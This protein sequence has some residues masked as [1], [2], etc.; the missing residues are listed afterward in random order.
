M[1]WLDMIWI[2]SFAL[3]LPVVQMGV[4]GGGKQVA[5]VGGGLS[6]LTVAY[7]LQQ[8][9]SG[10][11][12]VTVFEAATARVGGH[13]QQL[14][15]Q[16]QQQPS[17]DRGEELL[18]NIG[19]ATHLGMFAN[20]RCLLRHLDVPEVPVGRGPNYAAPGL[21]RMVSVSTR[22]GGA[23]V[24]PTIDDA[25]DW[26]V[27]WDAF[28]FYYHSYLEPEAALNAL[29]AKHSFGPS[30]LQIL[31]WAMATFEFDKR[32]DE[33]GEYSAGAARA[34]L[35]TQVFF[36]F[37]LCDA[38]HGELPRKMNLGLL[39][40]L[41]QRVIAE[42]GDDD[43]AT[44]K[45]FDSTFK[46]TGLASYFTA[47]YKLA[48]ERMADEI[49]S[50]RTD[51]EVTRIQRRGATTFVTTKDGYS[52]E[53]DS[54]IV[55]IPPSQIVDILDPDSFAAHVE[56]LA[57]IESGAV[58]VSIIHASQLPFRYPPQTQK[59]FHTNPSTP[60]LGIFDISQLSLRK[61]RTHL[62][63]IPKRAGWLSVAYPV[64]KEK[65]L[66]KHAQ[67]LADVPCLNE[68]VYPWIKATWS[69]PAARRRVVELQGQDG[70][71]VTGHTLTG[72]NK[73]S[74]LQ[75][76]N[77]LNLC[78]RSFGALP[79]WGCYFPVPLLP[80]CN[81]D[82]TFTQVKGP[83]EAFQKAVKSMLGSFVLVRVVQI[84]GVGIF[85]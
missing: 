22:D 79:P 16:Q 80:D 36:K 46:D 6:G 2:A 50:V 15:E 23:A 48:M 42:T 34:L 78:Y 7:V 52:S 70:L 64:Y 45:L 62:N 19:H 5:V 82:D 69:F 4:G 81:D 56:A 13:I 76:T 33:A 61:N 18:L 25:V 14:P 68:Q 47:D 75:I 53:F 38:F 28:W 67:F 10:R 44:M 41:R 72:V 58:G 55:T 24:Q 1:V 37:L 3:L 83:P 35:I 59:A 29:L 11:Y 65:S 63:D 30:F 85:L 9:Q 74:E 8:R 51:S 26:R 17:G 31:Y 12:N 77:A 39:K 49:H 54:V 66:N 27:G 71:F 73:A 57:Q 60:I 32:V 84:F 20:L 40:D 43:N 21:F